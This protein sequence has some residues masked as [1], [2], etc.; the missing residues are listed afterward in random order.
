MRKKDLFRY[1]FILGIFLILI[2]LFGTYHVYQ[3]YNTEGILLVKVHY[4]LIFG[5]VYDYASQTSHLILFDSSENPTLI[6]SIILLCNI[7]L[8]LYCVIF[9]DFR[10]SEN[11]SELTFYSFS[12][13]MLLGITF[14]LLFI[15]PLTYFAG[16]EHYFPFVVISKGDLIFS[17]TIDFGYLLLLLSFVTIFP[18]SISY[19]VACHIYRIVPER[20]K[21]EKKIEIPKIEEEID[22]DEYIEE[23]GIKLG[24]DPYAYTPA[25]E[26]YGRRGWEGA[27]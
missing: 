6:L 1:S 26:N 16:I 4:T 15:L 9:K 27:P 17:H 14:Y 20:K 10:S 19:F 11:L 7:A 13:L 18:Y 3:I 24:I 21:V 8:S 25:F 5:W 22:L 2:S 12:N 23:E